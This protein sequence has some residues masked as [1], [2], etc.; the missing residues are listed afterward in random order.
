[1]TISPIFESFGPLQ[2]QNFKAP[3][4]FDRVL[5]P[6]ILNLVPDHKYGIFFFWNLWVYFDPFLDKTV[7][8]FFNSAGKVYKNRILVYIPVL[9]LEK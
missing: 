9:Y 4:D 7:S 5:N 3:I 1:M 2:N 8:F 6:P